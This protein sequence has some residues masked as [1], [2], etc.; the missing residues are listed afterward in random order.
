MAQ[1]TIIDIHNHPNWYGH[2][3][4][5]IVSNMEKY[6]I[7]KTWLLSWETSKEEFEVVPHY[8]EMMDPRS[9]ATPLWMVIEGLK[10]YPDK[11]I[12]GWAPDP[13]DRYARA[14]LKAAVD[15]HGIKIFG[16]FKCRYRY[17]DPDVITTFQYCGELGLP[18]LFHLQ[19]PYI[20]PSKNSNI[21]YQWPE[22]YGG[23]ITVVE[24]MC[25]L[26]PQTKFIGHGPGFWIA[27]SGNDSYESRLNP[28]V[29]G[30]KL[31]D[32][33]R[34]YPN[35]YCDLS[36]SSGCTAIK[37]DMDHGMQFLNEFQDRVMFGRDSFDNELLT[38]LEQLP[39]GQNVTNKILF[40]NAK[41]LIAKN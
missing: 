38:T 39:L 16:E 8:Y 32:Y 41:K 11:F 27:I 1:N 29:A 4:D 22:W 13:R 18:V 25:K 24:T 20:D 31:I 15:I 34:T 23:D 12:G 7:C 30:G 14:K 3:L 6:G 2:N 35:L 40:Q 5:A 10:K 37:R 33:M 26:C 36:A 21:I 19:K 9:I 28:I 17:D